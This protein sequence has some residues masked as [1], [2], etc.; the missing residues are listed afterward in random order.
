MI[1]KII[2]LSV[3]LLG[4]LVSCKKENASAKIK[5]ENL[6]EAQKRDANLDKVPEITFEKKSYDF[7]VVEEGELVKTTFLF[8]N[9]GKSNLLILDAKAT[10]GCTVPD[11]NKEPI[12]PGETSEIKVQFNTK[13][14]PN[15]Q[16]KTVTITTNTEKGKEYLTISGMVKPKNK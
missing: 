14:R 16:S 13:G 2:I 9:T 10:C 5:E 4:V 7:G 15:K 1:K 12:K 11:W 8:T 3:V 6:I